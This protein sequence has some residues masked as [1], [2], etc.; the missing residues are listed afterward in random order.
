MSVERDPIIEASPDDA[1]PHLDPELQYRLRQ[2]DL[3]SQLGVLALRRAD[4]EELLHAATRLV[5]QGL[6]CRFCKVLEYLPAKNVFLVRAGVGWGPGVIGVAT[7]GADLESPAGFALKTGKPV[8]SNHLENEKRFRT[9]SLLAENGIRR[10]INVILQGDGEPFG[11]LEVDSRD[12]DEFLEQDLAFLQ[13]AANILGMAIERRSY[14][15]ALEA[16]MA[17]QQLLLHEVNHRVKN[18]LQLVASLLH[19]QANAATSEEVRTALNEASSRIVAVGLVHERL[20]KA[21]DVRTIDLGQYLRDLEQSLSAAAG[22][23]DVRINAPPD[24]LIETD[25]AIWIAIIANELV[26]NAAK[27]AYATSKDCVVDIELQRVGDDEVELRI[28]D[29]GRGLPEGFNPNTSRGLGMR[30]VLALA[31]Q[32]QATFNLQGGRSNGTELLLRFP[33]RVAA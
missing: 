25:R 19:L 20:Y 12:S 7:V 30:V 17:R 4:F 26:A 33:L 13:G 8:I 23:C 1:A 14:Q 9:P 5:A 24:V 3:L 11:V 29:H 21:D 18:S 27:H 6:Q 22:Q 28:A 16:S 2:Q 31:K 15:S 10:A 32:L